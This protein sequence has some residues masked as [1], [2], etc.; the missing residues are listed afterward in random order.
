[1][2]HGLTPDQ[3]YATLASG[4]ELPTKLPEQARE[5]TNLSDNETESSSQHNSTSHLSEKAIKAFNDFQ[6]RTFSK[7]LKHEEALAVAADGTVLIEKKGA[8]HHV[9]FTYSEVQ[10]M[11]GVV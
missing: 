3:I 11:R 9:G 8:S 4:K 2:R 6:T 10:K 5:I 7:Q 1:M